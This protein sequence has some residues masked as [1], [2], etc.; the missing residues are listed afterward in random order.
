MS[1]IG[2]VTSV[3]NSLYTQAASVQGSTQKAA[4]AEK[5]VKGTDKEG[6]VYEAS[7]KD[8]T[9]KSDASNGIYSD[10]SQIVAKLKADAQRQNENL[11]GIVEKLMMGQSK[12]YTIANDDEDNMWKFLASGEFEVDE[13][14]KEQAQ[15]DV[16]EDG[17]WGVEQ[18][19]DRILDFAKA[20]S[21]NDP[22]KA[23]GLLDAFKEGYKQAE[24]TWG[25]KLPGISQKT[26][27]AVEKKFGD[28]M[29]G[30]NEVQ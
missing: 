13:A 2:S 27:D 22:T 23:Q 16:A 6:V 30:T 17:Y 14:T 3:D 25:G 24:K 8:S 7:S 29:N 21:G 26:Y 28:W 1:T 5:E 9:D 20:L 18:T 10:R 15:K 4:E 11:R 19:S 12:A